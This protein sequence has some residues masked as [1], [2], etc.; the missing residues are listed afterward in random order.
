MDNSKKLDPKWEKR[1]NFFKEHGAPNTKTYKEAFKKLKFGER[2]SL[3]IN[4]W[5]FIFGWI[6]FLIKGMWKPGL[7]LAVLTIALGVLSESI[8]LP[9]IVSRVLSL[10]I[11]FL[12]GLTANYTYYRYEVLG[13]HDF[14]MFKG[15][16]L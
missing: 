13:Q 2:Y 1:F 8:D 3:N 4:L 11:M 12:A 16:K 7:I 10:I 6:Y 15:M 14:N 9:V 5:A